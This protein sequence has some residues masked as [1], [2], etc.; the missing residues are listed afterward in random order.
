[1]LKL[2]QCLLLFVI[3]VPFILKHKH[4]FQHLLNLFLNHEKFTDSAVEEAIKNECET[5]P[6]LK[7]NYDKNEKWRD[8]RIATH[9]EDFSERTQKLKDSI[10][11]AFLTVIKT[12]GFA[13]L[14]AC[15]VTESIF[16]PLSMQSIL[17]IVS[18]FLILWALIG[19]LGYP[20]RTYGGKTLPEVID[21]FWFIVLNVLGILC[22]FFSQFYCWVNH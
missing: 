15:V 13:W 17:Q 6:G 14:V 11:Q 20:I 8:E 4:N 10:W 22:L 16:F 12:L 19:K 21:N 2:F 1:M 9:R 5:I 18:A 3:A 7:E